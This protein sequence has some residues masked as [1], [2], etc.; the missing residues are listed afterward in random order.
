MLVNVTKES[1]IILV[2]YTTRDVG[3]FGE[4]LISYTFMLR[5]FAKDKMSNYALSQ[6]SLIILLCFPSRSYSMQFIL[7]AK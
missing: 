4:S 6:Q 7:K 2:F 1:M 5:S 3:E